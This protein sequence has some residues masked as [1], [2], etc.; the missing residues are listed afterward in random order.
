MVSGKSAI[1][2]FIFL[3]WLISVSPDAYPAE[4]LTASG[5]SIS[6]IGYLSDLSKEF[7][8]RTGIKV[9]V[10]GG[11]S[12]IGIDDLRSGRADFAA[13]CRPWHAGDPDD[14]EFIQV[15]WDAL[16]FIVH[17]S[18]PVDTITLK[19]VR[20]IYGGEILSWD[21]LKGRATPIEIYISRAKKGLSGVEA[22]TRSMVFG[23]KDPPQSRNMRLLASTGIVEQMVESSPDGFATTGYT[24]AR[25]RNVKMLKV[26]G[27][28]P[29]L[30]NIVNG[31]YPLK[32]PLFLL[33]PKNAKPEVKQFVDFALSADGQRFIRSLNVMPLRDVK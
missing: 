14:I 24:S 10:R 28:P 27:I 25:K 3:S 17:P 6:N 4:Y 8:R 32:R 29:T 20:S 31:S 30:R 7:E 2:L 22:S 26:N 5:C 12:V 9:F 21:L 18:N 11:G 1:G 16:V 19:E 23:G 33:I 15:A 13:S